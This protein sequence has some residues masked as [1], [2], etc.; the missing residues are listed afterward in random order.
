MTK[1]TATINATDQDSS[2]GPNS[3]VEAIAVTS[4]ETVTGAQI[5]AKVSDELTRVPLHTRAIL[6]TVTTSLSKL[7]SGTFVS[8]LMNKD[9][10]TSLIEVADQADPA[11]AAHIEKYLATLYGPGHTPTTGLS[12]RVIE[13]GKPMVMTNVSRTG[14]TESLTTPEARAFLRDN[15]PP[16]LVDTLALL[17]VPMRVQGAVIGTIGVFDWHAPESL[18][19]LD[20]VWMQAVA[21]R[22]GVALEH[23][24]LNTAAIYRL[25]RLA[26]LRSVLLAIG[27]SQDLRLTLEVIADQV[28]ARLKADAA[29]ILLL[30]E[31]QPELSIATSI[32]F[33]SATIPNQRFRVD[34]ARMEA[35]MR[36]RGQV[37]TAPA[38]IGH[39]Q[40]L[41]LFAREGFQ[42]YVAVPL[43]AR[44][45]FQGILE[46][47]H[48]SSLEPDQEWF[49]FLSSLASVAAIAIDNA[50]M[51]RRLHIDDLAEP[52]RKRHSPAPDLGPLE[53]QVL[54]LAVE[55]RSNRQ[56][57]T[58]VHL[59]QNT[60]KFH[61]RQILQ[62]AGVA[63][64]TELARE[65]TRQGWL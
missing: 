18:T 64:R 50:A 65:A 47:F 6:A 41:A 48:R 20:I 55:G 34:P 63:N 14:L 46:V 42:A 53:Q 52:L 33:H 11:T 61:I 56:I 24:L 45:N 28:T 35:V 58:E 22:T 30:D 5:V 49:D 59:S 37:T 51:Q 40:R 29:D 17:V 21:N 31:N 3:V 43:V 44:N 36:A 7:R 8:L 10:S 2:S 12:Q 32:G 9:P 15:P 4:T 1:V 62:K 60:I 13:T 27:S 16:M 38:G 23:A 54:R 19:D 39:D 57:S 25:E 26:A